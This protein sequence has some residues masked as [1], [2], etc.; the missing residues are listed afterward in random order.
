MKFSYI[1]CYR[2]AL[3]IEKFSQYPTKLF[4]STKQIGKIGSNNYS[5]L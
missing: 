5:C 2:L 3:F 4:S 1:A